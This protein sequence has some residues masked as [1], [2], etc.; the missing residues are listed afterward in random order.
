MFGTVRFPVS[1]GGAGVAAVLL[2][3]MLSSEPSVVQCYVKCTTGEGPLRNSLR[4]DSGEA[5]LGLPGEDHNTPDHVTCPSA[6]STGGCPARGES[7]GV[8]V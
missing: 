1:R 3:W 7:A 2:K 6:A 4:G 8:G 5:M